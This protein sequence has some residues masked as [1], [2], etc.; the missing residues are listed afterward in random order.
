MFLNKWNSFQTPASTIFSVYTNVLH[1]HKSL[2]QDPQSSNELF[3]YIPL[4]HY[5]FV[6][7]TGV[8]PNESLGML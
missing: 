6:G 5:V 2:Y 1:T 7:G 3:A 8:T 4:A